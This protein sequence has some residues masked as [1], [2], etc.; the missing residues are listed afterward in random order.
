MPSFQNV[1]LPDSG[2]DLLREELSRAFT[3]C[4]LRVFRVH[5]AA[6]HETGSPQSL[7]A[8]REH[9]PALFFSVNFQ[10]L[11]NLKTTV[12]FLEDA[13]CAIAVWCVDNPWN[14][15]SAVKTP[16][17]KRLPFFVT[18]RAFIPGLRLHGAERVFHMPLAACPELFCPNKQRDAAFPPPPD[19]APLVFVGRTGFP[20]K[21]SFFANIDLPHPLLERAKGMARGEFSDDEEGRR[22]DFLWWLSRLYPENPASEREAT[23]PAPAGNREDFSPLLWPGKKGRA[24]ACGAEECTLACRSAVLA[25]ATRA[26]DPSPPAPLST[27]AGHSPA[28]LDIFGDSGWQELARSSGAVRAFPPVDYYARLPGLYRA[29]RY[30]LTV[31]SMQLPSGLNQRHF[32]VWAAGGCCLSDNTPGLSLFPEELTRPVTYA[33]PADIPGLVA[34]LEKNHAR[35]GLVR[36]WQQ[37]I[38]EQHTYVHR[39][40]GVLRAISASVRG[41]CRAAGT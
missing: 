5:P 12:G 25:A 23:A 8:L 39:I 29:A 21:N 20:G 17:W 26:F 27:I 13:G 11:E 9:G 31:T 22:P 30:S 28:I 18:D 40:E 37:V 7:A 15:L 41:A 3:A 10:G 4:G 1:L 33:R 35:T 24:P 19:L 6:L 32:D 2:K 36:G 34:A 16:L 38:T 14:L